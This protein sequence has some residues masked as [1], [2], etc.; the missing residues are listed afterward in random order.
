MTKETRI[1]I[2]IPA[3]ITLFIRAIPFIFFAN[4]K[5]PQ[6]IVYLGNYLPYAMMGLLVVYSLKDI[7]PF[8]FPFGLPELIASLLVILLHKWKKNMLISIAGG[9]IAY[10]MIVQLLI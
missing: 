1:I 6:I 10:M 9:T 3:L 4:K 7:K 5:L 2:L 8:S